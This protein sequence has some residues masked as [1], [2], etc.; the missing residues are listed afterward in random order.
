[1]LNADRDRHTAHDIASKT[2]WADRYRDSNRNRRSER[3]KRTG[4]WHFVDV[5]PPPL[6]AE[7]GFRYRRW[8]RNSL[9]IMVTKRII[10]LTNSISHITPFDSNCGMRRR[11]LPRG[12]LLR[13]RAQADPSARC[14][15]GRPRAAFF[16]IAVY[17]PIGFTGWLFGRNLFAIA[18]RPKILAKT[19]Q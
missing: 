1:M 15:R 6:L 16:K 11:R 3:Y 8:D 19:C 13:G 4:Q 7:T 9:D 14:E 17:F 18:T 2:T 10:S 12:F 5:K